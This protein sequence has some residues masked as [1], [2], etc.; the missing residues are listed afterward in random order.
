[1]LSGPFEALQLR[2]QGRLIDCVDLRKGDDFR[3]L[4]KT[5]AIGFE[6]VAHGFIG[7]AR[8]FGSG[9]D[10]ME[11][12]AAAFDMPQK[13]VAEPMALMRPFDEAR[14]IGENEFAA[15]ARRNAKLRM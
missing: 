6:F 1:L 3:L 12:H 15:I 5:A 11:K 9:I 13:P 4:R 7:L 8:M 14:N 10:Q 2:L